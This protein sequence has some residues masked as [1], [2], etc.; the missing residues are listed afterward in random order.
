MSSTTD[1]AR[2]AAIVSRHR[3]GVVPVHGTAVGDLLRNLGPARGR[4][5]HR[6]GGSRQPAPIP[7]VENPMSVSFVDPIASIS[8]QF[9]LSAP[10]GHAVPDDPSTAGARPWGLC[11]MGPVRR[12]GHRRIGTYDHDQ[13]L[14][15][16]PSGVPVVRSG[17]PHAGPP[18]APT[19]APVD[20][21]D[22]PSSE[23]YNNDYAPD[24]PF[25]P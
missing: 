12:L 9:P 20:G 11:R 21:E 10:P 17:G 15:V 13:Q 3:H 1:S 7:R 24:A 8:G 4:G 23:D 19:T 6:A 5:R 14:S 18:T 25:V 2:V 16:D 22:P